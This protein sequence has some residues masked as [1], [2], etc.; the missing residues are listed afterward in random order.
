[1]A[2][3]STALLLCIQRME[4]GRND[5]YKRSEENEKSSKKDLTDNGF[6]GILNVEIEKLR[7]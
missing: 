2:F 3:S 7:K 4:K 6:D 5:F 1:M